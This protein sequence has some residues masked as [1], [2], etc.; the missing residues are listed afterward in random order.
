MDESNL[1]NHIDK[2]EV[3]WEKRFYLHSFPKALP[4]VLNAAH[5]W[6]S[7][8]TLVYYGMIKIWAPLNPLTSLELLLPR[9]PDM[10]VRAQAV[11]WIS[12]MTEDQLIDF[13]PQLMQ[14]LKFDC[15]D[16]SPLACFLLGRSLES[17]RVAHYLYWL[18]GIYLSNY[19]LKIFK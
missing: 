14:A 8:T 2:R 4:K 6:D 5:I 7:S 9:F 12:K 11:K 18:L 13:L 3:L 17:P 1:F 15:F 19:S 10:F 16:S